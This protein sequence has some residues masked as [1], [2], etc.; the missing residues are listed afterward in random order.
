MGRTSPP[1]G[2][3]L[4]ASDRLGIRPMSEE[5]ASSPP[6]WRLK[7]R[8]RPRKLISAEPTTSPASA[9][10]TLPAFFSTPGA[11]RR[12]AGA[13]ISSLTSLRSAESLSV[14]WFL[15]VRHPS[16]GRPNSN[17]YCVPKNRTLKCS[18]VSSIRYTAV[19][20]ALR[21]ICTSSSRGMIPSPTF[22]SSS[23]NKTLVTNS[24]QSSMLTLGT[25]GW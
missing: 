8:G 19:T 12:T 1:P 18:R 16:S 25:G 11:R 6:G 2:T 3:S 9:T 13:W 23:S 20:M 4:P 7:R 22:S 17:E 5:N 21:Y 10:A 14:G 24:S 15:L